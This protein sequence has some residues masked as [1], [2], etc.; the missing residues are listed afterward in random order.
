MKDLSKDVT[1][2]LVWEPNLWR[3]L[4]CIKSQGY[5]SEY[6][7]I[8][9]K[10]KN[11]T[12]GEVVLRK[13]TLHNAWGDMECILPRIWEPDLL[14]LLGSGQHFKI[15]WERR[16]L[17]KVLK[18]PRFG[19]LLKIRKLRVNGR[20][21]T[22]A[23]HC[24]TPPHPGLDQNLTETEKKIVSVWL[25]S[26]AGATETALSLDIMDAAPTLKLIWQEIRWG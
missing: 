23:A 5:L 3:S 18:L 13:A 10:M 2:K 8:L 20:T 25:M 11:I 4:A 15:F 6:I 26:I 1:S 17:T 9:E 14:Q 12:K 22:M 24:W 16:F 19:F 7:F 21:F